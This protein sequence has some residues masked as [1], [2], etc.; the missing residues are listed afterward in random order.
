ME[1]SKEIVKNFIKTI[2][3]DIYYCDKKITTIGVHWGYCQKADKAY[4]RKTV[5][6]I[7]DI[8][9]KNP[10]YQKLLY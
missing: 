5:L 9:E 1:I 2:P 4:G 3:L 10:E 6:K 8:L 7:L